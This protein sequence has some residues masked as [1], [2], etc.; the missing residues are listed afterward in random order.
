MAS[1]TFVEPDHQDVGT[2]PSDGFRQCVV[3]Q[4]GLVTDLA[5]S[6]LEAV[7][8][9]QLE[10]VCYE[11]VHTWHHQDDIAAQDR[12]PHPRVTASRP[13][14]LPALCYSEEFLRPIF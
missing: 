13:L 9:G 11:N 1:V 12:P 4:A 6:R 14:S 10:F 3:F 2:Q 7:L 5:T 8:T